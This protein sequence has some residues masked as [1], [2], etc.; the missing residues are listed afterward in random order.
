MND[1][2]AKA[3]LRKYAEGS[4]TAEEKLLFEQWYASL[5]NTDHLRLTETELELA[6]QEMLK[7]LPV[8][9]PEKTKRLRPYTI[10]AA[11]AAIGFAI[12]AGL[13]WY[14]PD[15]KINNSNI[16]VQARNNILPGDNKAILTLA[17]G[18]KISLTEAMKGELAQQAGV[19]I[20]KTRDGQLV[21]QV[22]G[23]GSKVVYNTIQTP[24]G[25][26]H[27]VIL[28]DGSK[29]WLNAASWLRFPSSLALATERKVELRG[30]AYFEIAHK[31]KHS[32]FVVVTANQ[33]I[34]VLGTHFNVNSYADESIARTTLLEGAVRL[35]TPAGQS[36]VLKPGQQAVSG[37]DQP[38]SIRNVDVS[39]VVD[40][41]EGLF[42]FNKE[43][44]ESIMR[45]LSRW[46]D[47]DVVFEN[48]QLKQQLFG[49][50]VSRFSTVAE[51]L[52]VLELT[53][54]AHFKIEGRRIMVVK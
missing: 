15:H 2:K 28:P 49:G 29:V 9:V 23:R 44:L 46:Y 42:V 11:A 43:S 48:E 35:S 30:E 32:L 47:V 31:R 50:K 17:D 52:D 5:N 34:E 41:K 7:K 45:K 18:S 26:Q 33:E 10:T 12:A 25:G 4:S 53:D 21:Y 39:V 8:V 3:L 24:R 1:I 54:L 16:E 36:Y 51:V 6:E 40:W 38:L 37:K 20:T 19:S 27:Q 13:W 22:K 14:K